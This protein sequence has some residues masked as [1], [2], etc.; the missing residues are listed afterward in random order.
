MAAFAAASPDTEPLFSLS[1]AMC[2]GVFRFVKWCGCAQIYEATNNW[3]YLIF[4][5]HIC[6]GLRPL[7]EQERPR[8]WLVKVPATSTG[9][10]RFEI[11]GSGSRTCRCCRSHDELDTSPMLS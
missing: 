5:R 2:G 6:H 9:I 7:A 11:P 4:A 8:V 3:G 1:D 10:S